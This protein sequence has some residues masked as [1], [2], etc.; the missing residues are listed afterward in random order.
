MIDAHA[1]QGAITALAGVALGVVVRSLPP[2][3]RTPRYHEQCRCRQ[4]VGPEPLPSMFSTGLELP[5]G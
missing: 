2:R 3:R 5:E 4:Y 1:V